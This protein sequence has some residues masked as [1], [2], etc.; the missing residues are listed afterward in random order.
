MQLSELQKLASLLKDVDA[1]KLVTRVLDDTPDG[2]LVGGSRQFPGAGSI[3]L[4]KAG[5]FNYGEIQ[6]LAHSLFVD[7]YVKSEGASIEVQNGTAVEGFEAAVAKQLTAYSY[8]VVATGVSS[9]RARK[10]SVI[11]DRTGGAKPYTIQYLK[12]RFNATVQ[13]QSK[14]SLSTQ[15]V[16]DIAIVVGGDYSIAAKP[17]TVASRTNP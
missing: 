8:H 2:L 14:N 11:I 12:Q 4:P 13:S 6:E 5:A 1:D 10:A 9:D 16:P 17:V 3:L 7:S 15:N